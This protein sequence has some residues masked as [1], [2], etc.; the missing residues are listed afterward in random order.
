MM[1]IGTELLNEGVMGVRSAAELG[2]WGHC[3]KVVK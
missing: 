2:S 1:P 3:E